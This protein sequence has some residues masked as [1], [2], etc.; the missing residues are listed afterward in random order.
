MNRET[1]PLAI[2]FA[3]LFGVCYGGAA[4]TAST[5]ASL[6]SWDFA[7]EHRIPFVPSMSLV[8]LTITPALLYAAWRF[9]TR[10]ELAPLFFGL[11]LQTMIATVFFL[12]IP[13]RAAFVRPEVTGWVRMP[14]ELADT[15]NLES[16]MFPSL[17]VAFAASLAFAYRRRVWTL[18]A[19]A[20]AISTWLIYEH[21]LVDIL[22]GVALAAMVMPMALRE[23]TWVE[24]C[25]LWQC[26][27]FSRR[28][29]RYF[30]IFLAIYGPS[31]LHWRRYRAVRTG[32]CT[33]Q[34]ID[35]LLDG[36]R[37]CAG[38]PYEKIEALLRGTDSN[39][40]LARLMAALFEDLHANARDEFIALV[41]TMQRDR[42]RVLERAQWSEAELDAHHRETFTRSVDLM[43]LTSGC[44]ARAEEV[45][46]L[47]R[48]FA[49]CSAVRDLD[50]DQ[51]KGLNNIPRGVDAADWLRAAH[52]RACD[53]LE[54]SAREIAALD[55]RR[56]QRI[57]TIFQRSIAKYARRVPSSRD[58][59]EGRVRGRSPNPSPP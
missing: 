15:V 58:R 8:Y 12:L 22:G 25:C 6:P 50:D 37:A 30:V 38:E 47:I 26:A 42:L 28:H 53:D 1:A 33:A 36:D 35:D 3:I 55:D 5:H 51:R 23:R 40:S 19:V 24:L 10:S 7:F 13:Q 52:A 32:F 45:P 34:W 31:L 56:A 29:I 17:H 21:H 59:E 27:R 11:S 48:A 44:T 2:A 46:S 43:L 4:W 20:V 57:L 39:S 18:W 14:F 54:R 16:N 9:R 41:R 49:W